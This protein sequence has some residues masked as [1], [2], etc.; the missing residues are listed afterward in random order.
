MSD[1]SLESLTEEEC[2]AL[3]NT[4]KYGRVAVVTRRR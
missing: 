2:L 4:A 1:P 3:L